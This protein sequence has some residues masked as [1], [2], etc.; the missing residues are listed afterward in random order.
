MLAMS[1]LTLGSATTE[2]RA[3]RRVRVLKDGRVVL[4]DS[5]SV[6]TCTIRDVSDAGAKLLC[7]D[8]AAVPTQCSLLFLTEAQIRDIKVIWRRDDQIGVEF[9]G[10]ARDAPA[11]KWF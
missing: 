10:P 9:I 5:N 11:R 1:E 7:K 6:V 4:N 8:Q 2:R 3:V